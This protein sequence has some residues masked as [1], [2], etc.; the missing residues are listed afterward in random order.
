MMIPCRT[1]AE[2]DDLILQWRWLPL[3]IW[4]RL[5]GIPLVRRLGRDE[6]VSAGTLGLVLAAAGWDPGRGVQFSTYAWRAVERRILKAANENRVIHIPMYHKGHRIPKQ[7]AERSASARN[8]VSLD[9]MQEKLRGDEESRVEPGCLGIATA[10]SDEP[11]A[12]WAAV[13]D[14]MRY[15]PSRDRQMLELYYL[16]GKNLREIARLYGVSR[17]NVR[18]KLERSLIKLREILS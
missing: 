2:R 6:A 11:P 9:A 15:L 3:R 8:A 13:Q 4:H 12:G 1:R 5:Q 16:S 7:F 14:A 18:R 10:Q 17:E